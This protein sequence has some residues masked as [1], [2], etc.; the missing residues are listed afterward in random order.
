MLAEGLISE[1]QLQT[2]SR[3]VE[4]KVDQ[5]A[6]FGTQSPYPLPEEALED[7]WVEGATTQQVVQ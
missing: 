3:Q 1:A 2:I 4:A 5:A 6:R 7:V